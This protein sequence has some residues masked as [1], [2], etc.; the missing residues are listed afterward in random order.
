MS[1]FKDSLFLISVLVLIFLNEAGADRDGRDSETVLQ[2]DI[3]APALYPT[4]GC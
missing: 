2:G 3:T 1:A 4:K